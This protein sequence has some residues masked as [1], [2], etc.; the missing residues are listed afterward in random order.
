MSWWGGAGQ[1]GL[2]R[3]ENHPPSCSEFRNEALVSKPKPGVSSL[4]HSPAQE[5]KKE[6]LGGG[7]PASS[8]LTS[9][10]DTQGT[11]A[12]RRV[13]SQPWHPTPQPRGTPGL[14]F[15]VKPGMEGGIKSLPPG[16]PPGFMHLCIT[17]ILIKSLLCI[18]LYTNHLRGTQRK[19]RT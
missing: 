14:F 9:G 19:K 16:A 7:S 15:P 11:K 10:K 13:P 1:K 12:V 8:L 3:S 17:Q 2:P 6:K 18:E 5:V 4:P